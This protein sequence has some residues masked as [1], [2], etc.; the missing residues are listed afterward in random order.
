MYTHLGWRKIGGKWAYLHPDGAIG[1][2]GV[3][4]ELEK[5]LS[6]YCFRHSLTEDRVVTM[7][8]AH[9]FKDCMAAH[10]SI[11]LM[12]ICFLAPLREFLERAGHMPRFAM[13]IKGRSGVHKS[14][15][16]SLALSFFGSFGYS[17]PLPASFQDTA[18]SIRRK[19]FIVKDSLLVVDDF[20]P[21]TSLQERRKME[22]LVQSL[23]RAYGNGDDRGRMTSDRKLESSMPSPRPGRS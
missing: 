19:A 3:R 15:A 20:H 16:S 21:V 2:E 17:D 5:V 13:W 22:G 18:N 23:S 9:E 7:T 12:G 14:T 1:A 8:L 11:P 10:I 4:V 6:R